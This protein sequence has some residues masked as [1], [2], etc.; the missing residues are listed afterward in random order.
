[1]LLQLSLANYASGQEEGSSESIGRRATSSTIV[2]SVRDPSGQPLA[3]SALV[4]LYSSDGTPLGQISMGNGGSV[5]FRNLQPAN[6]VVEVEAAGYVKAREDV[7]MAIPGEDRV[8]VYL[9]PESKTAAIDLSAAGE[10]ILAPKAKKEL[11]E[12]REALGKNDLDAAKYHLEKAAELAPQHP[13]VLYALASLSVQQHNLPKA[14]ALLRKAH[15]LYPQDVP[16][17]LALGIVMTD[18]GKFEEASPHLE[19][20][21]GQDA[22]SWEG[23]WALAKCYYHRREFELALAQSRQALE[24]S[25]GRAPEVAMVLAASLT[26]TAQY[27][28]SASVLRRFLQEHPGS[29]EAGRA[30]RWLEYLKRT[31][32]IA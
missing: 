4:H 13:K 17:Q 28:E 21:L 25:K 22:Q 30:R 19:K 15:E 20:A 2:V 18:E 27:E 6:Y 31:G 26:A 3:T 9:Q 14:E 5:T 1:V 8:Q 23:R 24:D 12:G 29:S 10:P 32:K 11:D 7:T 16:A